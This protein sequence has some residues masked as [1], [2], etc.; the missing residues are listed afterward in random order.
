MGKEEIKVRSKLGGASAW[1]SRRTGRRN[2]ATCCV[3]GAGRGMWLAGGPPGCWS[4]CPGLAVLEP[5]GLGPLGWTGILHPPRE[6]LF[7]EV[8]A[9]QCSPGV[10][11]VEL[12]P[13]P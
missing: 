5:R 8:S 11:L 3:E 4:S 6:A 7:A 9:F 10:G 13:L 12:S 1:A 2:S